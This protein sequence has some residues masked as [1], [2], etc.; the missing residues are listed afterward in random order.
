MRTQAPKL[1]QYDTGIVCVLHTSMLSCICVRT[2]AWLAERM[3]LR[4]VLAGLAQGLIHMCTVLQS[5]LRQY[6]AE[7]FGP[8]HTGNTYG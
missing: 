6:F 4:L 3:S 1:S 7:A 8:C 5:R 2:K